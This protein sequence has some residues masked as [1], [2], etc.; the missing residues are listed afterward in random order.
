[1][2]A[3]DFSRSF[4]TFRIDT[5]KKP[6]QTVSHQPPYS[7]NNARIQLDCVCDVTDPVS[8]ERWRD[9]VV[10]EL[11]GIDG[12]LVN[13]GGPPP[14]G[15]DQFDDAAWEGAF[16]LTLMSAVRLIRAA[17]PSMRARG[18][19]AVV[20]LTSQSIKEP[21]NFLLLSAVMRSGVAAL[22]KGL[23]ATL[24][25]ATDCDSSTKGATTYACRPARSLSRTNCHHRP[26]SDCST[27]YVRTSC[28]PGGISRNVVTSRSPNSVMLIVR[29]IGVAVIT[30]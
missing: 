22:V 24:A 27:M 5:L 10:A 21:D 11:G 19:G 8:I 15:F 4:L 25:A 30:R 28:R 29:G 2:P 12:L 13:A 26:W 3:I 9:R 7:L 18:G 14:G 1:M 20:A 16:Q 17:L 23:A 6:P